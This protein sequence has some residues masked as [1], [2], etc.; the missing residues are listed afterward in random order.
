[1]NRQ[2]LICKQ[3]GVVTLTIGILLLVLI[4]MVALYG[5]RVGVTEQRISA[6][7]YRS[8]EA[9]G[10][11]EAGLSIGTEF[12]KAHKK[13]IRDGE[14]ADGWESLG[15]WAECDDACRE[16][17]GL[18]ESGL[19][20]T[21][22]RFDYG[23]GGFP[24]NVFAES[25]H[26][27]FTLTDLGADGDPARATYGIDYY[28][29]HL[30]QNEDGVVLDPTCVDSDEDTE[31]YA[32]L[33]TSSGFSADRNLEGD[34][35]FAGSAR[36]EVRQL[37]ASFASLPL[38]APA[39]VVAAA[40]IDGVGTFDVVPNPNGGG[41]GVPLSIWSGEDFTV[42]GNFRTCELDEYMNT[43][44]P[45]VLGNDNVMVCPAGG[46]DGCS[47]EDNILSQ[48]SGSGV[49]ENLDIVDIDG[50]EGMTMDAGNFPPDLFKFIFGVPKVDYTKIKEMATII[51]NCDD[52][53]TRSSGFYWV[54]T[55]AG[56]GK[57]TGCDIKG[58][59]GTP[60]NPMLV[61]AEGDVTINSNSIF[62]GLL[63]AFSCTD[64]VLD[65][66]DP[67]CTA[68]NDLI[69]GGGFK[70]NGNARF[71]GSMVSDHQMDKLNGTMH[72]IFNADVLSRVKAMDSVKSVGPV[73][74]S[75]TDMLVQN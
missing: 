4:T 53:D 27:Q 42:G 69:E 3:N 74:G 57:K 14:E 54:E 13:L 62:F 63:F 29:C 59:V 11:A 26:S 75:W 61:V 24:V 25:E 67:V 47:C 46:G 72:V 51:G 15:V 6:N 35:G 48:K 20:G 58:N 10:A 60:D 21:L 30:N 36:S 55:G 49:T 70:G 45:E 7:E 17:A 50:N 31:Q 9:F 34:A 68:E 22:Y 73:P 23:D 1:M 12:L 52:L 44:N 38:N 19:T 32:V 39:P 43:G 37:I 8:K 66:E 65:P 64:E 16:A 28:L 56:G 2:H 71:Y 18:E 33:V 41:P 40:T 5:A